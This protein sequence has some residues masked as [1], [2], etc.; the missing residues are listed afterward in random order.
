MRFL[1]EYRNPQA[2]RA[3]VKRILDGA[4]RRWSLME[5]CGGQTH[6]LIRSGI[7][8]LI[9]A[10]VE[11][12][13]GPGCP[14]CVTPV[15]KIDRALQAASNPNV[16]LAT[17]G[18]MMRVP[19]T[20]GDLLQKRAQGADVRVIY[21]PMDALD[22]AQRNPQRD[23]VL[24]AVGFETTAPANAM[25]VRVA[26]Q[27]GLTNFSMLCS[28]VRVPPAVRLILEDPENRVQGFIAPGHV[29]TV[30]GLQE[31]E[32][33][34]ARYRIPFVVAGFEPVDLLHGVLVLVQMLEEGRF[35][36]EN[37]YSRS[38]RRTGNREALKVMQEV[39][40][41]A[42]TSWRGIGPIPRSG[43]TLRP[44]YDR[45]DAERRFS[46]LAVTAGESPRCIAGDVLQGKKRPHDCAAFGSDC[47]PEHP[48]GAPM[49]SSEGAC[50]AYHSFR[51]HQ[52]SRD[53]VP[54]PGPSQFP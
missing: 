11:L 45:Y 12:I 32:D 37:R 7:D 41:V 30:M 53:A 34:A 36:V 6:T 54:M 15:E 52:G 31:Y 1:D 51:R 46:L 21:S 16:I 27:K 19:G 44:A 4:T 38:V 26:A 29:C 5:V 43:L 2:A 50:A 25:A 8:Q 14:V 40:Q 39:L 33:L 24:F 3:L 35:G 9:S 48:L 18:D 23:V 49:V 17:Y 13:H 10:K 47:T 20:Q 22:L 28:H 42:D